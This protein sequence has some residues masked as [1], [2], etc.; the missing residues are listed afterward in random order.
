MVSAKSTKSST[1][2]A[3]GGASKGGAK[4]GASVKKQASA[5]KQDPPTPSHKP[6]GQNS[7]QQQAVDNVPEPQTPPSKA[8]KAT[9]DVP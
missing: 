8:G 4:T 6:S 9:G 2:A 3:K 7:E 5:S 1:R